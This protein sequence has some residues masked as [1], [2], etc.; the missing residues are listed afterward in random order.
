MCGIT[1]VAWTGDAEPVALDVVW[2]MTNVLAHRGPDDSAV[3]HSAAGR[4]FSRHDSPP[5]RFAASRTPGAALGF[6]RLAIIDLVTGQQPLANEDETVW[7]AFNGEIYN[8]CELRPDLEKR[9]HRFRTH[10]DTETIVHLYEEY[11]P[12][13]VERLR[14]MFAIAIWDE[15]RQQLFLAR[16]RLG[17]K[18][19]FYR[20][21]R[22]RLLFGSELKALLQFPGVPREVDPAALDAY[23]TYQ[24]VPH[25][26]CILRGYHKLPPGHWAIYEKGQLQV[27][28][29]WAPPFADVPNVTNGK[30]IH[31]LKPYESWK[32][33]LRETLTEAVRLRLRSDVPLG[34]FLSGGID[35][36]IISGLMQQLSQQ[37]IHTFSIGFPVK[38]FDETS[39]AR[40]AAKFL[41][42]QHHE[43]VVEP[44]ALSI[45][46]K[47]IWHYDEPFADSSAIPTMYLSEM[48]RREVTV[49]LSG[50]GGDELFC[51]YDRY[52]AVRIAERTD[53]LPGW[54][55]R[56]LSAPLWQRLPSSVEQKSFR[57]RLK[58]LL[59][60]L[61]KPPERRYLRWINIFDDG[62]RRA[63]YTDELAEQ[64]GT[65]DSAD[66]LLDAY[67]Q[68][69]GRD[70]ITRTTC[71]D[72]LTYLP[73][74]IL[75]K[76][77]IASM[78]Y[79]LEARCPFLDT[80][81]AELAARMPIE[82]KQTSGGGKRILIDTFRD[83]LPPSIQTR[84]KMGFGVPLDHWFRG[85]L[86]PLLFDTLLDSRSLSRGYFRSDSVCRL[87]EEH[88]AQR[89]DHSYRLWALLVFE[90]WQ[91]TYL[92]PAVPPAAP[93]ADIVNAHSPA[94]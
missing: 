91:R 54:M 13:C 46:P 48:T 72:V 59:A 56:F 14:G 63:L 35:S 36:T 69:P 19:L 89:W 74:D 15:R 23:L 2:R 80:E 66:F 57:R 1:G 81:V 71:A 27:E 62:R 68:C 44:H 21:E 11:G 5:D 4:T 61:S 22:D 64:L 3:Y 50:D 92:D 77:D 76:V 37:P 86:R 30:R 79:G 87:I 45:L 10:S 84:S 33:E 7:I 58:R 6:R 43:Q 52:R 16:D 85:E 83:L 73:C 55:K 25:P 90:L 39:Y 94:A 78:A 26:E 20:L 29:Y 53:R 12:K 40:E 51:G 42:T 47:L 38:R 82:F 28:R 65:V 49:A 18:P 70:F 75:T 88:D 17:K 32:D 93:V 34:A 60:E 8:Y 9:G 41:G 31:R 67:G 24:Y